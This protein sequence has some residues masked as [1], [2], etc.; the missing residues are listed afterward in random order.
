[1]HTIDR[2]AGATLSLFALWVIW[3]S[4][5]LPLGTFRVP[6]PAFMPALLASLLLTFGVLIAATGGY[7][8]RFRSLRWNELPHATA[9]LIVCVFSALALERVGYRLTVFFVLVFLVKVVEK[10]GWLITAIFAVALA[11][12][13]FFLFYTLL[14]VP[15]PLGP[16]GI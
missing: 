2:I 10:R 14:R 6:G 8:E 4:R 16:L 3:E 5:Q 12:G 11:F 15:L 9:I 7:A 1:M 13:S